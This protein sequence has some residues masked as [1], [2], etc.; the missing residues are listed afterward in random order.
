[1]ILSKFAGAAQSL[2]GSIVVDPQ[3]S[4]QVANAIYEAVSMP[5][6]ERAEN[7]RKLFKYVDKYNTAFWGTTF[8]REMLKI[9]TG[10]NGDPVLGDKARQVVLQPPG[11]T[12]DTGL[13]LGSTPSEVDK[14][15]LVGSPH[16]H[17]HH[18][19]HVF[20]S[21]LSLLSYWSA[22]HLLCF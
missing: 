12:D 7:H 8:V 16:H 4:E 11:S 2:N 17:H 20:G 14:P 3:N 21:L 13:P 22:R 15:A 19:H 5:A 10:S 9:A 6:E 1:M 18:H